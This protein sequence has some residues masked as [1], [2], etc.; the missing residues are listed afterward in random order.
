MLILDIYYIKTYNKIILI[1]F[2]R[3]NIS[4]I[5]NEFVKVCKEEGKNIYDGV[6]NVFKETFE[7]LK[8]LLINFV[9]GLFSYLY[10]LVTSLYQILKAPI[11]IIFS[12]LWSAIKST[13]G[14]FL[15]K[16]IEI[17]KKW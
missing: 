17:I 12:A 3:M 7:V 6:K 10:T 9:K 13:F 15:E 8:N 16:I 14:V 11:H 2:K 1:T 4:F 5:W